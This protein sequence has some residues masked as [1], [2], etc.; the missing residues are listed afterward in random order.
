MYSV[1]SI[2]EKLQNLFDEN[3]YCAH[4]QKAWQ[5]LLTAVGVGTNKG[6]EEK[7]LKIKIDNMCIR[8]GYL[9]F[10]TVIL[11]QIIFRLKQKL[12]VKCF[13]VCV[14]IL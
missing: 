3:A 10:K 14:H 6:N 13:Y 8:N 4:Y 9:R 7:G 2:L 5:A 1:D 11:F 12:S